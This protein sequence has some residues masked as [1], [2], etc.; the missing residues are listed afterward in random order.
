MRFLYLGSII[1]LVLILVWWFFL[2]TKI[3]YDSF[4]DRPLTNPD[5]IKTND[6]T[7]PKI[8]WSYWNDL[9][10]VPHILTKCIDTWI[11]HN[12]DYVINIV[13]NNLFEQLTK[14]NIEKVFSVTNNKKYQKISDFVRL[15]LI[16]KFGGIW[17]DASIICMES[18][19]WLHRLQ[20]RNYEFIGYIAPNEHDYNI[21][22]DSWFLAAISESTF[23]Y[24]W[25]QEFT[26]SLKYDSDK[27]YCDEITNKY[28]M[29]RDI[30]N[31]LPYLTIHLCNWVIRRQNP[32]KYNIYLIPSKE[33]GEPLY[34]LSKH[35]FNPYDTINDIRNNS[36]VSMKLLKIT[37]PMRHVL[38]RQRKKYAT[39]NKFINYVLDNRY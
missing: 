4:I 2:K 38:M 35:E 21:V 32:T 24:D 22:I 11:L 25:L 7:I 3:Q 39:N 15:T 29:V 17:M 20:N 9:S 10:K 27:K 31:P 18:L 6:N 33:I 16:Y 28:P 5:T 1:V 36:L 26:T 19:N 8:I 12:D 30:I 13:D 14:I 37:G 34:Y 23:I